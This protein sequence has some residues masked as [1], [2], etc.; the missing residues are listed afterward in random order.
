M[1]VPNQ[2]VKI[3]TDISTRALWA[4]MLMSITLMGTAC[5]SEPAPIRDQGLP[6]LPTIDM[7]DEL[8]MMAQ[9]M[10]PDAD[11]GGEEPDADMS[12]EDPDAD[13]GAMDPDAN[14]G[15]M[16]P[17]AD[18]DDGERLCPENP[19]DSCLFTALSCFGG[20]KDLEACVSRTNQIQELVT[21][22]YE[23]GSRVQYITPTVGML[24]PS[25]DA[26]DAQGNQCYQAERQS[27]G[28]Y[29]LTDLSSNLLYDVVVTDD[30]VTITCPDQSQEVCSRATFD[31]NFIFPATVP[32]NCPMVDNEDNCG[33]DSECGPGTLCCSPDSQSPKQCLGEEFCLNQRAPEACEVDSDCGQ[34]FV[35]A[36]CRDADRECVTQALV[37]SG[38]LSCIPDQ[39]TPNGSDC[40]SGQV[41]CQVG[42]SFTC[43]AEFECDEPPNPNP[44]CNI[45][46][47]QPC[48]SAAQQCCY[49]DQLLSFRCIDDNA[50]CRTNVCF[51]DNDCGSG[52][53]CC[54]A[55]RA[56]NIP[57]SCLP[58]CETVN[59]ACSTDAD[60]TNMDVCCKYPGF[61]KGSCNDN[62]AG[63]N[64]V[65][66][67]NNASACGMGESCCDAAPLTSAVCITSFQTCPPE[68]F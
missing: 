58:Q 40:M 53:E 45:S 1:S 41:C 22:E 63:C 12:V 7:S 16:D 21:A 33:F 67:E 8:D 60:C 59:I 15:D 11:M 2:N 9:D 20:E 13:M 4:V 68:A 37:D 35:C 3:L 36:K 31:F 14:M 5:D 25:F 6:D 32:E 17:D 61:A 39:C 65:S 47:A 27:E 18:M 66:C 30:T 51:V 26:F 48:D 44:S 43:S 62:L 34:G 46:D 50:P 56:A 10:P 57:G 28:V 19:R 55:N 54:G 38:A 42:N 23:N 29:Q 64:I 49:V 24:P 52:E